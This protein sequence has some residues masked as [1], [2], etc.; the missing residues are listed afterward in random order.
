MQLGS[1][2]PWRLDSV[3]DFPITPVE[4]TFEAWE[5]RQSE[6]E[7][8]DAKRKKAASSENR[9][10]VRN[11]GNR[12]GQLLTHPLHTYKLEGVCA[13]CRK[14]RD[15]RLKRFEEGVLHPFAMDSKDKVRQNETKWMAYYDGKGYFS[16][17]REKDQR[18]PSLA[19]IKL[20]QGGGQHTDSERAVFRGDPWASQR[21]LGIVKLAD[22]AV[23]TKPKLIE[24]KER[25][26]RGS[27]IVDSIL[28]ENVKS[29]GSRRG[30][31]SR[32]ILGSPGTAPGGAD[33]I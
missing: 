29:S 7:I 28:H 20:L 22:V 6:A 17:R 3:P 32:D 18:R 16:N 31:K 12:C 30:R 33:W 14:R 24:K 25:V 5:R 15:D 21:S 1:R 10:N 23:A 26:N 4:P 9:R 8:Q 19:R 27:R 11:K 13:K 2:S